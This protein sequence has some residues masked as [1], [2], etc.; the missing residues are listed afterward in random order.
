MHSVNPARR[1]WS[2]AIRRSIRSVH[3]LESRDQSLRVGARCGGSFA[4]SLPISSSVSPIRCAKTMNAIRRRT[5][6]G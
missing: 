4:S 5:G 3:V 2:S 1:R 6:L